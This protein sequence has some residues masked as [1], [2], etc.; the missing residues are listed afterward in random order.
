MDLMDLDGPNGLK[1]FCEKIRLQ[2]DFICVI[3]FSGRN[4][5]L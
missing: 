4:N 1:V 3:L 5:L 2:Y